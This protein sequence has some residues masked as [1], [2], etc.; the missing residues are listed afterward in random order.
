[1]KYTANILI[2]LAAA[3]TFTACGNSAVQAPDTSSAPVSSTITSA[4]SSAA[5]SEIAQPLS[6]ENP[7]AGAASMPESKIAVA[8]AAIYRGVV[9][10]F[11]VNDKGQTVLMMRRAVGSRFS[12]RMNFALTENTA[13]SFE[14]SSIGNGAFLEVYYSAGTTQSDSTTP[15]ETEAIAINDLGLEDLVNYNGTLVE[16]SPDPDKEG[17]GQLLLDP[18]DPNGMQYVFN[19]DSSTQFYLDFDALKPGVQLNVLHSAASTRSLPPQSAA[20]EIA[21][22]TAPSADELPLPIPDTFGS[23]AS[24]G[25]NPTV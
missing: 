16:V 17:A 1:M 10:D 13:Y 11:A 15:I 19:Y 6:A 21:P 12:P 7:L 23:D 18:I 5:A 22:Y 9:E 4:A 3:A 24:A 2:A 14:E 20:F 8:D 25:E